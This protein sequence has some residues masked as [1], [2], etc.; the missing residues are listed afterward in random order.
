MT[1]KLEACGIKIHEDLKII[2]LFASLP[3]EYDPSITA[4][5]SSL[6][7]TGRDPSLICSKTKFVKNLLLSEESRHIEIQGE[8]APQETALQA[9]P[10]PCRKWLCY[11]CQSPDHYQANCPTVAK[12]NKTAQELVNRMHQDLPNSEETTY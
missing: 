11:I 6:E 8:K 10:Q 3:S 2:T 1:D 7:V 4:I 5:I 9:I 12:P